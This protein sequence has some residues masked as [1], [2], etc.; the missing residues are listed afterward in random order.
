MFFGR[1]PY[2]TLLTV[3]VL[4]IFAP[5]RGQ[6]SEFSEGDSEFKIGL[7][8]NVLLD[9]A[10]VVNAAVEIPVG[11]K[12][13][14]AGELYFAHWRLG[15][16]ATL[17]LASFGA[18]A[19]WWPGRS[20]SKRPLTGFNVGLY[21]SYGQP[22]EVQWGDGWQGDQF[23]SAGL[24]LGYSLPVTPRMNA[25]LVLGG[26]W[27]YIPEVRRYTSHNNLMVWRQTRFNVSRVTFTRAAVNLV[28][29]LGRR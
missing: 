4:L 12:F 29:R 23:F 8:T 6:K 20:E 26:G 15:S 28:W 3:C 22:W 16:L 14:I 2:R 1:P 9:A 5:A 19:K 11:H 25:E 17:H 13:S 27:F 24:Q 18:E 7:R 10:G 21:A